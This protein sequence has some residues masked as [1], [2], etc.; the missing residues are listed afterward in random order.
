MEGY[1]EER[2][3]VPGL[4]YFRSEHQAVEYKDMTRKRKSSLTNGHAKVPKHNLS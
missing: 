4:L 2:G 1:E 3:A